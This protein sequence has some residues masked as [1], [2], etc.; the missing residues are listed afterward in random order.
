[1]GIIRIDVK[2]N[3]GISLRMMFKWLK[4]FAVKQ[5]ADYWDMNDPRTLQMFLRNDDSIY[6]DRS[7]F[8]LA[9]A[10]YENNIIAYYCINQIAK[11]C[12]DIPLIIR[13]NG[14]DVA[15]APNNKLNQY[16]VKLLNR[17]N[18]HQSYKDFMFASVAYRLIGG[19]T[20]FH[21]IKGQ[22][23]NQPKEIELF[24]PDRVVIN[25][26]QGIA[27]EYQ[28]SAPNGQLYTYP[29]DQE[30]G[31][32][33]VMLSKTF[34]PLND[35]YGL[36]PISAALSAIL[37][38][39]EASRW[40][41]L[42]L[43]N[44]ARPAGI[45]SMVDRGDNAANLTPEQIDK[46]SAMINGKIGGAKNAGKAF[47]LNSDMKWQPMTFSP[48]DMDW[49]NGRNANARDIALAFGYPAFLLGLPDASSTYNNV[50][51]AKLSL[52]E[53]TVI[54]T[55]NAILESLSYWISS[56]TNIAIDLKPDL[57]KVSALLPRRLIARQNARADLAAGLITTNEARAEIGYDEVEG[58][59]EI[60][61]PAAKLPLNFDMTGLTDTEAAMKH[62]LMK[63]GIPEFESAKL[64]K[65]AFNKDEN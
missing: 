32:S 25:V 2:T 16:V 22:F 55:L 46:L 28:Y 10:G 41:Q 34:N 19:N 56:M 6:A 38:Y 44:S 27:K 42:M 26:E 30:T 4:N 37:Q 33:E 48:S 7:Y 17:P 31:L 43:Q 12:A 15:D 20:Y 65:L 35:L 21:L 13:V 63:E 53:E 61:V 51:Q 45:L 29:I 36:S 58:G 57:D 5:T 50:E 1:M 64:A 54:P 9:S 3:K 62:R 52:Y 39:N 11:S 59:D 18:I 24:R 14:N 60:M 8:G 40:N 47:V 49:L 23:T